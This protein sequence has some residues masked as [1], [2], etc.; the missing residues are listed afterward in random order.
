MN[1]LVEKIYGEIKN[2]LI[3]NVIDGGWR[4]ALPAKMN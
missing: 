3:Q 4:L 1:E 2:E